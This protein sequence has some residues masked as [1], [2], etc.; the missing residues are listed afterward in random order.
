MFYVTRYPPAP[1][2]TIL[3]KVCH[4][5][6]RKFKGYL[7]FFSQLKV[8]QQAKVIEGRDKE[9]KREKIDSLQN[10]F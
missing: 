5:I 7:I 9:E 3:F 10:E 4:R 1:V 2:T 6:L 8:A